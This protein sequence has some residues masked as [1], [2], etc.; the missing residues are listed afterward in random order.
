LS[1]AKDRAK[2]AE[3]SAKKWDSITK[4]QSNIWKIEWRWDST[5]SS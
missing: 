2:K 4:W 1:N 3:E 5:C